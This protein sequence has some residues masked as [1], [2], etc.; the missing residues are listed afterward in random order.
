[1]SRSPHRL[2]SLAILL[3]FGLLLISACGTPSKAGVRGVAMTGGGP[4][5]ANNPLSRTPGRAATSPWSPTKARSAAQSWPGS[6]PTRQAG[7]ASVCLPA[8]TRWFKPSSVAKRRRS[9]SARRARRRHS[10][11]GCALNPNRTTHPPNQRINLTRRHAAVV[12]FGRSARGLCARRSAY[13]GRP[14]A[15]SAGEDED[16]PRTVAFSSFPGYLSRYE[17]GDLH[18]RRPVRRRGAAGARAEDA[19]QP[20]VRRR[21]APVPWLA[22]PPSVAK[23]G[24]TACADWSKPAATSRAGPHA[25]PW[26]AP[27]GDRP[28]RGLVGRPGGPEPG[29]RRPVVVVQGDAFDR[30]RIGTVVCVALTTNLRW[31]EAPGN[32]L[33]SARTTGLPQGV[34]REHLAARHPRPRG[35]DRA[36]GGV[37]FEEARSGAC[38]RH[39]YRARPL[40]RAPTRAL[41]LARSKLDVELRCVS[42]RSSCARR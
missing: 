27:T 34:G 30:S 2:L 40:T 17:D 13:A 39:R 35:A 7:S 23:I 36:C 15:E 6:W 42:A 3:S 14:A 4:V 1:M 18:P 25:A 10:V 5:D 21:G 26:S 37:A 38:A 24:S 29:F 28:G 20:P 12:S 19:A 11:A 41:E 9:P 31:A 33:L 32:V 22:T 16:L 8:P